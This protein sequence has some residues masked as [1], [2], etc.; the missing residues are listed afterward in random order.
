MK[1]AT[2]ISSRVR[3]FLLVVPYALASAAIAADGPDASALNRFPDPDWPVAPSPA[4]VGSTTA[5]VAA[6]GDWLKEHGGTSWASVVIKDGWL[7]YSGRG[8]RCNV[9][10]KNDCGSILKPLQATVL[11]AALLQGRLKDIDENAFDYWQNPHLTKYAND[12]VIT[13]RQFAQYHDRWNEPEPPGTLDYNNSSATAAGYCIAG[14]F[15]DVH[16]EKPANGIAPIAR[17]EVMDKI[18][19]DWG[20]W[21]WTEDFPP[22][23]WQDGPRLVLDSSV[24][25]L[26]KLG[27]LW[28]RRG[29]WQHTRIFSE[30]FYRDAVT[31]WSMDDSNGKFAHYGYWWFINTKRIHLPAVPADAFYAYGWGEPK[32]GTLLL[33][34]PSVDVVAVLSM[35][36]LS[37]DG[38]WD[39]IKNARGATNDGPRPWSAE[40][41]KLVA[42][43]AR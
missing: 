19:A 37:D 14:L 38:K 40:V 23:S 26:A 13:F 17:R 43:G 33:I 27:Y 32:R 34:I 15:T 31:D 22:A 16:G 24:Y 12:R 6:Y 9:H 1:I 41:M 30:S 25:E 4:A 28:L 3:G 39:V 18:H 29:R 35:E 2:C 7:L 36:R 8:P 42:P 11:G 20:L 21:H 5:S 10:L